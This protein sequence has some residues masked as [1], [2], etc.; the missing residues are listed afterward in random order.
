MD[1]KLEY[2]YYDMGRD[3]VTVLGTGVYTGIVYS[4]SQKT[5][6]HLLRV[7]LNYRF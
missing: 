7:G 5:A 3:S 2:L 6:G 1:A 4:A